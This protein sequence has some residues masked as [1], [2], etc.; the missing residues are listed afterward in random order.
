MLGKVDLNQSS[1]ENPHL[2]RFRT[3]VACVGRSVEGVE[4]GDLCYRQWGL[5]DPGLGVQQG[6][7]RP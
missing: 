5:G 1:A 7:G 3:Q 4:P 2:S 6:R